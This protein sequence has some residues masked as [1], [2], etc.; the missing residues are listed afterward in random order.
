MFTPLALLLL[1]VC[2]VGQTI[3]N[4]IVDT[5]GTSVEGVQPTDVEDAVSIDA[6]APVEQLEQTASR[7]LELVAANRAE[8]AV[9]VAEDLK[10]EG[11]E[12]PAEL[13]TASAPRKEIVPLE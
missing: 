13:D 5:D 8:A 6:P 10:A 12:V 4:D 3:P 11:S 7:L 1:S 2:A 9:A